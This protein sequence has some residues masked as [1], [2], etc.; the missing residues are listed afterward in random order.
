MPRK[1]GGNKANL[2]EFSSI[3]VTELLPKE[4]CRFF[5]H[6]AMRIQIKRAANER[7]K[8]PGKAI[9]GR[10]GLAVRPCVHG[11]HDRGAAGRDKA[12]PRGALRGGRVV[13]A[14]AA[15][16]AAAVVAAGASGSPFAL[17]GSGASSCAQKLEAIRALANAEI[18]ERT[19]RKLHVVM[20]SREVCD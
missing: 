14:A 4:A 11:I 16:A 13:V 17:V 8:Q 18:L 6:P 2:L 1:R 3:S 15:A 20:G 7:H 10:L 5:P 12:W 19:G 9:W